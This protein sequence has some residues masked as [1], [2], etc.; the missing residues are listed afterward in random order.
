MDR[1]QP[2]TTHPW[3]VV[4]SEISDL[5]HRIDIREFESVVREFDGLDG[6]WFFSGQGRSGLVA[7]M[8]AMRF[9]HLGRRAH[10]PGEATAPSIRKGDGLVLVSG[11][12]ETR[13]SVLFAEIA[14]SEGARVVVV[15]HE[16]QSAL[17]GLGDVVL[18]IPARDSRQLGGSLFEQAALLVLD[19]VVLAISGE[20]TAARTT[21]AYLHTNFQ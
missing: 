9:M 8:V 18:T 11:S 10:V 12:G 2:S 19:A 6:R 5:L 15:T 14:K 7:K 1:V 20:Q 3:L 16:P 21:L 4:E 17:A 13:V